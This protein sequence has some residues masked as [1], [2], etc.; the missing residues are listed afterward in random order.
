MNLIKLNTKIKYLWI[1]VSALIAFFVSSILA[2]ILYTFAGAVSAVIVPVFV[3][4]GVF[5]G[6][7]RY[8]NWGF[9]VV[10]DHLYIEH[11]VIKKTYSMVPYVRVQHID[12]D[13]GPIDRF[14]GLSTLRVYTAGSKGADIRIPGLDRQEA[15]ELQKKLRDAAIS[16]EKGFDAV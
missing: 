4:I 5:Y 7:K 2:G 15:S 10:E 14:L 6:V 12:T 13:R 1:S 9:K 3:L 8:S 11:G 16:S